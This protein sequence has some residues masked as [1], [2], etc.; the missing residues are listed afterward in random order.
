MVFSVSLVQFSIRMV[1]SVTHLG[2]VSFEKLAIISILLMCS[3]CDG[4]G[5]EGYFKNCCPESSWNSETQQCEECMSGYT[6]VNCSSLCPY[7]FYGEH[8]QRTCNCS[9]DLCDVST[10]CIVGLIENGTTASQQTSH[11]GKNNS[12]DLENSTVL[13]VINDTVST[14]RNNEDNKTQ[15]SSIVNNEII[16]CIQIF[17]CVDILLICTYSAVCI[18]DRQHRT[19]GNVNTYENVPGNNSNYEN[20]GIWFISPTGNQLL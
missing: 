6:G 19:V 17:G 4:L 7:P 13:P 20:V 10:G 8:C 9:R 15:Q 14:E 11:V 12:I 3:V 16:M 2:R 18:Y 1:I 5:C